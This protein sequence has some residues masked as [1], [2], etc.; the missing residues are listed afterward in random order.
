MYLL[1]TF[2]NF[3]EMYTKDI[4]IDSPK[5]D[6]NLKYS[7]I[8]TTN[9]YFGNVNITNTFT[10]IANLNVN[11]MLE[12]FTDTAN[13]QSFPYFANVFTT[14]FASNSFIPLDIKRVTNSIISLALEL[15]YSYISFFFS[16][17]T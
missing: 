9:P 8:T 12:I 15:S 7:G 3:V 1:E 13:S 4:K 10:N 11:M 5:I 14:L 17:S 16:L 2:E 6:P